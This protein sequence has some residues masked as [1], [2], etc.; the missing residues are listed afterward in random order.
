MPAVTYLNS[1][2]NGLESGFGMRR[3]FV[4]GGRKFLRLMCIEKLPNSPIWKDNQGNQ[5][6]TIGNKRLFIYTYNE[7]AQSDVEHDATGWR[8]FGMVHVVRNV[9]SEEPIVGTVLEQIP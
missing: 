1:N 7:S 3:T 4:P 5:V 9:G 8:E 6:E 2:V